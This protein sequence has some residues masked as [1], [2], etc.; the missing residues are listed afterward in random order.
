MTITKRQLLAGAGGAIALS[1]GAGAAAQ[2]GAQDD[3][4]ALKPITGAAK[5]ITVEER[6]ARIEKAQRLMTEQGVKALL[7]EPG[8]A[9]DYFTGVQW[10]RSERLTAAV[11]PAKGAVGIVTPAFE[12]PSVRES[13]AVGG[14]VRVWQEHESPFE[15]VAQLLADRG[16][17]S[18]KVGVEETVR[19]FAVD[20]LS[21]A[22]PTLELVNASP[23][24]LGCR[25]YKSPAEIA[26]MQAATDVTIAAYRFVHP[27]IEAGMSNS[28]VSALMS[29]A[30]RALG[31]APE[32][33]M[34]L[35]GE[36]SAYPHGTRKPQ[37]VKEDG[38]VLMD[39]GCTVHGYQSDISRT[40]VFGE[41]S[42]RQRE[43]WNTVH[44]G[45][46]IAFETMKVGTPAG[47]VDDAV[48][49]Y[50]ESLGYGP[51][52]KTPGLSHRTG[53]GIGLEGH[54]RVNFVHGEK[55][56]IAPDM[57]FSDEPGI[58]IFGEFGVRLEDCVHITPSGPAWFST[59]PTSI[60]QPV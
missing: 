4:D 8:A 56:K 23:I 19:Y 54:E 16:V 52:Y 26:L 59:P 9:M 50:Y 24:T 18:G 15:R 58:Y 40:F 27:R 53:H 45:Q 57:C 7:L 47:A 30:T 20:G 43:V 49:A 22:A 29:A 31:G 34:A 33:S 17:T 10:W 37:I 14:D 25:M 11:I 35:V 51:G 41:A 36:A 55:T 48:R 28:D 44:R 39:C 12:E 21:H 6:R 60:D 46:Q 42:K 1:A 3:L 2:T 32:F 13:L 5:P 38:I